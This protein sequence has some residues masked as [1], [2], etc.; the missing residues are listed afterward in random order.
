MYNLIREFNKV[1]SECH[2]DLRVE[3]L[4]MEEAN[5]PFRNMIAADNTEGEGALMGVVF[6]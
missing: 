3:K 6:L 2:T 1:G 4:G 5:Y